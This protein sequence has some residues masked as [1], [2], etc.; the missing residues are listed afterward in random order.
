MPGL[1]ATEHGA[2]DPL[3]DPPTLQFPTNGLKNLF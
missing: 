2:L 1:L 3:E